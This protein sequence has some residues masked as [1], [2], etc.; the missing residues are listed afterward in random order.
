MIALLLPA[1]QAAREAARRMSCSNKVKQIGLATHN[2]HDATKSFPTGST[3]ATNASGGILSYNVAGSNWAPL[4]FLVPYMELANLYPTI[5]EDVKLYHGWARYGTHAPAVYGVEVPSFRCPS[6]AVRGPLIEGTQT[7]PSGVTNYRASNGDFSFSYNN[8][9]E[10]VRYP[11]GAFWLHVYHGLEALTDG[12]SNTIIWSERCVNPRPGLSGTASTDANKNITYAYGGFSE[13]SIQQSY[14]STA[15]S[16]DMYRDFQM[17]LCM[18]TRANGKE[19]NS[20]NIAQGCQQSGVRWWVGFAVF[21]QFST[22][23]PPNGPS[24]IGGG[25]TITGTGSA[26]AISATSNHTGGVQVGLGDGSV[27]F[28]SD[29]VDCGATNAKCVL[30]GA[31][32][33]GVWGAMGSRNGGESKS[34]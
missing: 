28:V 20:G 5:V 9:G 31:S 24:C 12:T 13:F 16:G 21:T 10:E 22:V 2:Y 15:T 26:G 27:T 14:F 6:D 17:S 4:A 23:T 1:V 3:R 33:F 19:Y 8:T 34:L 11:R 30:D 7:V 32:L 18:A 25:L 29:T